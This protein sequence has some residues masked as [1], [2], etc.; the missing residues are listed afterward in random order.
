MAR[1]RVL[2]VCCVLLSSV[3]NAYVPDH[4]RRHLLSPELDA[5]SKFT[6]QHVAYSDPDSSKH[7][8]LDYQAQQ[9]MHVQLWSLDAVNGLQDVVLHHGELRETAGG[10]Q[11]TCTTVFCGSVLDVQLQH[12]KLL[13][14][15]IDE[16]QGSILMTF[17]SDAAADVF[18]TEVQTGDVLAPGME[19]DFDTEQVSCRTLLQLQKPSFTPP[20]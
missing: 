20:G 14:A 6:Q 12:R 13:I 3:A 19:R 7:V 8:M 4:V 16:P 18:A 10:R 15:D 2:M 9:H 1:L 5:V 17:E 11:I